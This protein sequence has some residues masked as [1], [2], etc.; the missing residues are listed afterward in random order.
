MV[1]FSS[2]VYGAMTPSGLNF[3]GYAGVAVVGA[4]LRWKRLG[5]IKVY[6][7]GDIAVL[8]HLLE[9]SMMGTY[10]TYPYQ[11]LHRYRALVR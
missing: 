10:V 4:M 3:I 7:S 1:D 2:R 6:I 11:E 5:S 8:A 9:L